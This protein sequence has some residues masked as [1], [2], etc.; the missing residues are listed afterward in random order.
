MESVLEFDQPSHH[1]QVGNVLFA[2]EGA[3]HAREIAGGGDGG[4][5]AVAERLALVTSP[6]AEPRW[7]RAMG[8][9]ALS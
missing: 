8:Q 7:R 4:A 2:A 9:I 5:E 6:R 3:E 1:D